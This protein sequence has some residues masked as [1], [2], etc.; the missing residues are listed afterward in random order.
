MY[1]VEAI[2]YHTPTMTFAYAALRF[3]ARG[4][5]STIHPNIPHNSTYTI[6]TI[7]TNICVRNKH[8]FNHSLL[9]INSKYVMHKMIHYIT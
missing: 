6:L 5:G 2:H 7:R 4:S 8:S 1:I 9:E 3:D